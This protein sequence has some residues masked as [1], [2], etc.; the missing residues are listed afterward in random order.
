[1]A[2][3]IFPRWTGH[4]S[5]GRIDRIGDVGHLP[6][7]TDASIVNIL[8]TLRGPIGKEAVSQGDHG[9]VPSEAGCG[10]G[11]GVICDEPVVETHTC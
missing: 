11:L 10:W 7:C 2:N 3:I 6:F 5:H 1:M 8:H 4:W 9:Q